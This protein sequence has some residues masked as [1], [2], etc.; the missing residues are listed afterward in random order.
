M[1]HAEQQI[2]SGWLHE[3][4]TKSDTRSGHASDRKANKPMHTSKCCAISTVYW[5]QVT[6]R[7]ATTTVTLLR[8]CFKRQCCTQLARP[9]QLR[10]SG[11]HACLQVQ[12]RQ[13]CLLKT[14]QLQG[15]NQ[16]LSPTLA[17][18][19]AAQHCPLSLTKQ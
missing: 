17:C 1:H 8:S 15:S 18:H 19:M 13:T 7:Q 11:M 12:C 4:V 14:S 6:A 2:C 10:H 3:F 16:T 9:T 5:P